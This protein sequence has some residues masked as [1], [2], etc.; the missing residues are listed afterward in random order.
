M[1]ALSKGIWIVIKNCH[2]LE[3]AT[4]RLEFLNDFV[5]QTK[6]IHPHFRLWIVT[7]PFDSFP[8]AVSSKGR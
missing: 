2:L 6:E 1:E 3:N 8:S 5:F 4:D 7:A